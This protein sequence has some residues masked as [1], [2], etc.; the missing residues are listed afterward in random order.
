MTEMELDAQMVLLKQRFV[1]RAG[2][3]ERQLHALC[4][5]GNLWLTAQPDT[6]AVRQ[7]VHRIAG[8]AG[9]FGFDDLGEAAL[10][11]DGAL[12]EP[13]TP[14]RADSISRMLAS[15]RELLAQCQTA[16][17]MSGVTQQDA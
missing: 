17:P 3:F 10:Q 4:D 7:V 11:L 14:E 13:V 15:V 8:T 1:V 12:G 5:A 16:R 9:M 2:E 6:D